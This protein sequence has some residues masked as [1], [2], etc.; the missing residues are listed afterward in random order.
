M[1]ELLLGLLARQKLP[2]LR[3]RDRQR[4]QQRVVDVARRE[5]EELEHSQAILAAE[6]WNSRAAV[7]VAACIC[8]RVAGGRGVIKGSS[9]GRLKPQ[10]AGAA[11]ERPQL[12]G[13]PAERRAERLQHA[14][15]RI[16]DRA[17]FCEAAGD[18]Q[19]RQLRVLRALAGSDVVRQHDARTTASERE[20]MGRQLDVDQRAAACAVAPDARAAV[21]V[22][23]RGAAPIQRLELIQLVDVADGH[24]HELLARVAVVGDGRVVDVDE[25][26]RVDVEHPHRMRTAFEHEP[27]LLEGHAS[28]PWLLSVDRR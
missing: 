11:V 9:P 14:G 4:L 1:R 22:V 21:R 10:H 7:H 12:D 16:L 23:T 17:G 24:R 6:D 18:G 3:T 27:V 8:R 15:A 20:L 25:R 5:R 2:K 26:K 19:L 13:V 28:D